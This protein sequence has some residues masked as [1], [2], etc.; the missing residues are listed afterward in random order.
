VEIISSTIL[1]VMR[2]SV[3]GAQVPLNYTIEN[4][5]PR[6]NIPTAVAKNNIRN[7]N[8][9]VMGIGSGRITSTYD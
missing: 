6:S 1:P 7:P 2:L 3:A 4:G 8:P 5:G 9:S